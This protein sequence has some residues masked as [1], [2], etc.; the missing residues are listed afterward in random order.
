MQQCGFRVD[1]DEVALRHAIINRPGGTQE[2]ALRCLAVPTS[3][4]VRE[5]C[6]LSIRSCE[7]TQ[8]R[9]DRLVLGT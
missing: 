3:R 8:E 1:D 4:S 9:V 6:D 2:G 7:F 5:I